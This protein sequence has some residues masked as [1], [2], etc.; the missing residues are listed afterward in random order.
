MVDVSDVRNPANRRGRVS[1]D[2]RRCPLSPTSTL[3]NL[4][5]DKKRF[6]LVS[7]QK[8]H[9]PQDCIHVSSMYSSRSTLSWP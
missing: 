9:R 7:V 4:L 8:D 6:V 3:K 1:N 2:R 5:Q